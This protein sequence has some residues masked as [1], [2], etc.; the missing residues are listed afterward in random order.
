MTFMGVEVLASEVALFATGTDEHA[1]KAEAMICVLIRRHAPWLVN[2]LMN[3]GDRA[4]A[5]KNARSRASGRGGGIRTLVVAVKARYL[6]HLA[7]PR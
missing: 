7:T 5:T 3:A 4:P 2:W 6:Y 1:A